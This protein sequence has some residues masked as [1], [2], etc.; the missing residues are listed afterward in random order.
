MTSAEDLSKAVLGASA[1][2]GDV[3]KSRPGFGIMRRCMKMDAS[4]FGVWYWQSAREVGLWWPLALQCSSMRGPRYHVLVN[5]YRAEMLGEAVH[6]PMGSWLAVEPFLPLFF[7]AMQKSTVVRILGPTLGCHLHLS[8]GSDANL[9]AS[10]ITLSF[11]IQSET[12]REAYRAFINSRQ[13]LRY[14]GPWNS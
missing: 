12:S 6:T 9:L 8:T 5:I 10:S 13:G 2:T 3:G 4:K 1:D 11:N 14:F 7:A